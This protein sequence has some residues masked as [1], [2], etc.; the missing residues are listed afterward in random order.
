MKAKNNFYQTLVASFFLLIFLS[1][2]LWALDN[3]ETALSLIEHPELILSY[4]IDKFGYLKLLAGGLI[5]Y[6]FYVFTLVD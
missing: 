1:V 4:I 3:T 5:M 6:D 2:A